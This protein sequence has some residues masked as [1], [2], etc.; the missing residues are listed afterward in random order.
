MQAGRQPQQ[1]GHVQP[2]GVQRQRLGQAGAHPRAGGGARVRLPAQVH[3]RNRRRGGRVENLAGLPV[4]FDQ[5][6]MHRLDL[7]RGDPRHAVEQ[8][9]V[10]RAL[11]LDVLRDVNRRP[12]RQLLGVPDR[13]LRRRKGHILNG[14]HQGKCFPGRGGFDFRE[15]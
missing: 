2:V 8:F 3:E 4:A 5:A 1:R 9:V 7:V 10:D 6:H 12:G 14:G 13:A 11:D 15:E